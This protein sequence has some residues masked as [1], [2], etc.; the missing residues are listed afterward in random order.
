[1]D[2][3]D[4]V[5]RVRLL[6]DTLNDPYPTPRGTLETDSGPTGSRYV[7]CETCKRQGWIRRQRS[8]ILCLACDGR[9]WRRREHD[10]EEWDAYLEMTLADAAEL[11]RELGRPTLGVEDAFVWER[12]RRAYDRHGSY[13]ELRRQLERLARTHPDRHGL[14]RAVL[15][16]HEPRRLD[17]R[18]SLELELGIVTLALRM[19][20]VR[21][22]TWLWERSAAAENRTIESLAA[23]GMKP[24][25]IALVLGVTRER[26]KRTL[27]KQRQRSSAFVLSE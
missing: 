25:K 7:P 4:R 15:V 9:G 10:D 17:E 27:R 8:E 1:V 26:V 3:A 22:P 11:P 16:D 19:R 21:V 13:Q 24:G 5:Q 23:T 20:S 14:V 2:L 6:L 18:A 12:L